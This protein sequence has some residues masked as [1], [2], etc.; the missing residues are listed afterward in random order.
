MQIEM[1]YRGSREGRSLLAQNRAKQGLSTQKGTAQ[2]FCF[3][4]PNLAGNLAGQSLCALR[5]RE[6]APGAP[7]VRSARV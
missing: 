4:S 6:Q 1:I 7:L 3:L 5:V 2:Q